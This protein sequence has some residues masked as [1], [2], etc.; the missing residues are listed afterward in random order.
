MT[1]Q[2]AIMRALCRSGGAA[3]VL[4]LLSA[5]ASAGTFRPAQGRGIPD[6]Y[7]VV[8]AEGVAGRPGGPPGG[9]PDVAKV[10][11][12]VAAQY[13]GR[14]DEVWEDA[15]QGFIVNMPEARAREMA[16]DARVKSVE[17]N[18]LFSAP[19]GDCYFG[20]AWQDTRTLPSPTTS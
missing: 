5:A 18:F 9:L 13:G 16:A 2:E 20:T 1:S 11:R 6:R 8:L 19:V 17:Q 15:L 7:T 3:L 4:L 14:V 12:G 10:A